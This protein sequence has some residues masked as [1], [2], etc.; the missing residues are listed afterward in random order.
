MAYPN[1][2]RDKKYMSLY[3]AVADPETLPSGWRR[4]VIFNLRVVNQLSEKRSEQKG[5][6][7]FHTRR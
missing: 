1:G 3:L 5:S 4:D 7:S 6:D 2:H